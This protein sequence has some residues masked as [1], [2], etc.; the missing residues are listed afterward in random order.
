MVTKASSST[1][2]DSEVVLESPTCEKLMRLKENGSQ[3]LMKKT[4]QRADDIIN[5]PM[6]I[7]TNY[8]YLIGDEM[9]LG[10]L[11]RKPTLW[12]DIQQ[13]IK[14]FTHN[15]ENTNKH[16][17]IRELTESIMGAF[18]IPEQENDHMN[19]LT[20]DDF[21]KRISDG[22]IWNMKLFDYVKEKTSFSFMECSTHKLAQFR[23]AG[24]IR[25]ILIDIVNRNTGTTYNEHITF[26]KIF[27]KIIEQIKSIFGIDI[28]K[29]LD[30]FKGVQWFI[31]IDAPARIIYQWLSAEVGRSQR[32]AALLLRALYAWWNLDAIYSAQKIAKRAQTRLFDAIKKLWWYRELSKTELLN[33]DREQQK[34]LEFHIP[35]PNV[36][37]YP[38]IIESGVKSIRSILIKL[39]ADEEYN[40]IDAIN[41]LLWARVMLEDVPQEYHAECIAWFTRFFWKNAFIFKNKNLLE[42]V[43]N[44][45][46]LWKKD[47]KIPLTVKSKINARSSKKYRDCKYSWYLDP[48]ISENPV[49]AEWQF[50]QHR[51]D[52]SPTWEAHHTILNAGKIIQWWVR[53]E[54]MIT[55]KQVFVIINDECKDKNSHIFPSWLS[56]KEIFWS[57]LRKRFLVPY[58]FWDGQKRIVI[59]GVKGFEHF[60]KLDYPS[61]KRG[62]IYGNPEKSL[63]SMVLSNYID[64]I[65]I[66]TSPL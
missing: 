57:L 44:L 17:Q 20:N 28:E 3:K 63:P 32:D 12:S 64:N 31:D 19:E 48:G 18:L 53:G 24:P 62:N 22:I 36:E 39:Y 16:E 51:E 25:K 49:G 47:G 11:R 65:E 45:D 46:T 50:F 4:S 60:L 5:L 26:N 40:N 2:K 66:D 7:D 6:D 23:N 61:A 33:S 13:K 10:I 58:V 43:E 54:H 35:L 14:K 55:A 37:K 52:P 38:I 29:S 34:G 1:P 59:F 9:I 8:E 41:D 27:R 42:N 56:A 30:W 21:Q 15:P